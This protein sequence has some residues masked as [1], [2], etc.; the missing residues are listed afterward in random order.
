MNAANALDGC[1]HS[2]ITF[3]PTDNLYRLSNVGIVIKYF[4][5]HHLSVNMFEPTKVKIHTHVPSVRRPSIVYH[6]SE[7]IVRHPKNHVVSAHTVTN[8]LSTLR[9][10]FVLTL[11]SDHTSVHT[12]KRLLRN[13]VIYRDIFVPT[14][15]SDHTNV[16]TVK[17]RLSDKVIYRCIFVVT[18]VSDHTSVRTVKRLFQYKVI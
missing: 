11:V 6:D 17:R 15:V 5:M 13:K 9:N 4:P 12:V 16:H 1:L 14:L 7:S 18:L 2:R 10:I 8:L 3:L